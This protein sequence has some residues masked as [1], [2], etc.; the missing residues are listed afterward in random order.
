MSA[1]IISQPNPK[2]PLI[3][4]YG[5]DKSI[6]RTGYVNLAKTVSEIQNAAVDYIAGPI[7]EI[8]GSNLNDFGP[9]E[10]VILLSGKYFLAR[11]SFTIYYVTQA[12]KES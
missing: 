11:Y 6:G 3:V 7:S 12:R 2:R 1:P 9:K 10:A 8:Y 4:V 5:V